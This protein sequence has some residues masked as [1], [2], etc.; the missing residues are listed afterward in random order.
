MEVYKSS[1]KE[2][3]DTAPEK[4]LAKLKWWFLLLIVVGILAL[5]AVWLYKGGMA[6]IAIQKV[7]GSTFT[8]SIAYAAQPPSQGGTVGSTAR[9]IVTAGVFGILGLVYLAG[10]FKLFFSVHPQQVDTAADLVKTL[11]GFFVGA[12]TGFLG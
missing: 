4:R 5:L 11:T 10:I 2:F 8:V 7:I 3:A 1:S 6:F 12:A 9:V